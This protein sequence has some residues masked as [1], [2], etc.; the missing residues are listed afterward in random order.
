MNTREELMERVM[1][2]TA[3]LRSGSESTAR[4]AI[5]ACE[6]ESAELE[7]QCAAMRAALEACRAEMMGPSYAL[8]TRAVE[9]AD[10]ALSLDAGRKVLRVVEAAQE[11]MF[12]FE[13]SWPNGAKANTALN[14][15]TEA[16]AA[17]GWKP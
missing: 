4:A 15:L 1:R 6:K 10:K 9:A 5:A 11:T 14:K 8:I 2:A 13:Q 7:A 17:L 12:W 16:L 3:G